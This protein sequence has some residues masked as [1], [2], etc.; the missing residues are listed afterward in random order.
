MTV[1]GHTHLNLIRESVGKKAH[2]RI[3]ATG[4]FD[5]IAKRMFSVP[6][7]VLHPGSSSQR[8]FL[9]FL[10]VLILALHRYLSLPFV[11]HK[12]W[13]DLHPFCV[14]STH[15]EKTVHCGE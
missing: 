12:Q 4:Y 14:I 8:I 5:S 7:R 11:T 3:R 2:P 6:M 9:E 10:K 13:G 1:N 15:H